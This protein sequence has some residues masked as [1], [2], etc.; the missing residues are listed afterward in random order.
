MEIQIKILVIVLDTIIPHHLFGMDRLL[1][2]EAPSAV[3]P[4]I[5]TATLWRPIALDTSDTPPPPAAS[6]PPSA[7]PKSS[8]TRNFSVRSLLSESVNYRQQSKNEVVIIGESS[9]N[10]KNS[11]SMNDV[12]SFSR[13]M[14]D[15]LSRRLSLLSYG[16]FMP[17][18]LASKNPFGS[19]SSGGSNFLPFG[20]GMPPPAGQQAQ[21]HQPT[22]DPL[23]NSRRLPQAN[24]N[25]H[26][27]NQ[28]PYPLEC[29]HH[30]GGGS[31]GGNGSS[32]G[33]DFSC[34]KC[35]KMFSTPHGLE[36]HARRSHNGKRPFA[37]DV[38]NKTFGHE[39]SLN[40]HRSVFCSRSVCSQSNHRSLCKAAS[41]IFHF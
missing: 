31:G 1:E 40:Q 4:V 28:H 23:F 32:G 39:I 8:P 36:V 6:P 15:A 26:H 17:P 33:A 9:G 14:N 25:P 5:K 18:D 30:R 41:V 7:N 2:K 16:S 21:Q 24:N 13:R 10:P 3:P 11:N 38:C 20:L 34:V 27:Q 22:S 12:S 35:E 19:I 37:C 29:F